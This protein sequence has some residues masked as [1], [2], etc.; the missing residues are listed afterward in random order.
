MHKGNGIK[1]F[2]VLIAVV[3]LVLSALG[4][5]AAIAPYKAEKVAEKLI[6]DG[7]DNGYPATALTVGKGSVKM[8]VWQDRVFVLA[9][10]KGSGW[11]AVAFNKQG[12]GMDGAN[13]IIGYLDA[14]GKAAVR[15]DL[16]KGWSHSAAAKQVVIEHAIVQA[17]GITYFEF[18]YPL[19][20]AEGF[21][22]KGLEEGSTYS[23]V[24]AVNEK[25]FSIGSKH[26]GAAKADFSL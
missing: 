2:A 8:A 13:M 3:I 20:F 17:D 9:S 10:M 24:L 18:S 25:S 11:I 1:A 12:K 6:V 5:G 14:A 16:G 26:T 23:L 15:N 19:S 7:I 21:A 4:A 22:L